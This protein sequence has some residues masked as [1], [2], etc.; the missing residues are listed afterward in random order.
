M[1]KKCLNAIGLNKTKFFIGKFQ[2]QQIKSIPYNAY[3]IR[4]QSKIQLRFLNKVSD[5]NI[6]DG[7]CD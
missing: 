6:G 5:L 1:K 4:Y 7:K 3:H 2:I